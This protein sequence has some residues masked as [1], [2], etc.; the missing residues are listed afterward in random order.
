MIIAVVVAG[1]SLGV[2]AQGE[3]GANNQPENTLPVGSHISE[4][5]TAQS[6]IDDFLKSKGWS[7]GENTRGNKTFFVS[8][9]IGVIQAPR[10]NR[11]YIASRVAAYNKAMLD[12]KKNMAEFLE[13]T[14]KTETEKTYTEGSFDKPKKTGNKSELS[15]WNKIKMLAHAK[16]DATLK[17]EGIDPKKADKETVKK[18]TA[19]VLASEEYRKLV[20]TAAKAYILGMQVYN[21]F[22]QSPAGSKGEIGVI[23]IWSPK[24]Q[25]MAEVMTT[26]GTV[27]TGIAK[28]PILQ[29]IPSNTQTL[30]TQFGVQQKLD[31]NGNLTL[32]SFGQGGALS[33]SRMAANAA[34]RKA[35][36]NAQAAIREFAGE[37]VAVATDMLEAETAKELEDKTEQYENESAFREKVKATAKA[38]KISGINTIRRW[39]AKHPIT[40]K[41]VYGAICIWNPQSS[42]RAKQLGNAM[43]SSPRPGTSASVTKAKAMAQEKKLQG[44]SFSG[45]GQAADDDAF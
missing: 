11:N 34:T 39:K 15:I 20:Q 27:P 10:S 16:L 1:L 9:G 28:K 29:Q 26:G 38:M 12:A 37:S 24:L 21:S 44:K 35:Q 17:E 2:M 3:P 42:A 41:Y 33:D 43:N 5:K 25:A 14:I 7:E 8:V 18:A 19:K 23:A 22:E 31:Q 6:M 40:G 45:A 13:L 32:V 4:A 36:M 30:L